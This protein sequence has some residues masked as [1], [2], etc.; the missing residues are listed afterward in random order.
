MIE[1][2][3]FALADASIVEKSSVESHEVL[4]LGGN[5][6]ASEENGTNVSASEENTK[7]IMASNI[8]SPKESY[9]LNTS[10]KAVSEVYNNPNGETT[11][12]SPSETKRTDE[13]LENYEKEV[14]AKIPVQESFINHGVP[15]LVPGLPPTPTT[16]N[17]DA[18]QHEVKD[19]GSIDGINESNDHK[20]PEVTA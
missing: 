4:I 14:T 7:D 19:D 13:V 8:I 2:S 5:I 16:S 10:N 20:L 15:V 11:I 9:I 12:I 18:P 17:Q 1:D 3:S 6:S